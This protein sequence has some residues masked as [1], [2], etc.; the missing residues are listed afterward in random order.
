M[1]DNKY[2]S[3]II[4][5]H[6]ESDSPIVL[7]SI[8][9]VEG[10]TPRESGTKMVVDVNG[11]SY[12]TVGGSLLEA[13]AITESRNVLAEQRPKL[14]DFDLTS[15]DTTSEDMICGGKAV[16]LFDFISSTPG[17][18]EIFRQ[19]YGSISSG[20]NFYFL[21]AFTESDNT[22]DINGHCLLFPDGT[23]KG[24]NLFVKLDFRLPKEELHN[25]SSTKILSFGDNKIIIDRVRKLKT[26]FCF[27][28]GHV[29]LP[30]VQIAAMA[31]F[32]VVVI[33][34][35]EEFANKERFPEASNIYVIEE[36]KDPLQSLNI[37]NDSFIIILTRGH[38]YDRIVLEQA[39][40]T[41][42]GYIGMISSKRKRD[43]VYRTIVTE[44]KASLEDLERVHS[45]I[46]IAIGGNTPE[47]IAV[48]IVAE[49]IFERTKQE[50]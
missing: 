17:N 31:G 48:S 30:T 9:S 40:K 11:K 33:D 24:D 12:G 1:N 43:A 5:E 42:A 38:I 39:L 29:A 37:D 32:R 23:I 41:D 20:N 6:L 7:V 2:I 10:S 45:P 44:G 49:M 25:I 8:I 36:F 18:R 50:K 34:D 14:M 35:R 16:L 28:A 27:G 26:L 21:T 13:A 3:G 47:E 15:G 22:I 4:C 19:M 46:G